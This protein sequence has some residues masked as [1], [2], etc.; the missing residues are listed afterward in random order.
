MAGIEL[1]LAAKI[2]HV[3]IDSPLVPLERVTLSRVEQLQAAEDPPGLR[4]K[5]RQDL[6]LRGGKREHVRATSNLVAIEIDRQVA[7][8]QQPPG[9][10]CWD[11]GVSF[12][13]ATEH[14]V[15]ARDE[16]FR[17][18]RLDDVIVGPQLQ[19]DD[20]V[21]DLVARRQHDDGHIRRRRISAQFAAY[22]P[23]R[24][25]REHQVEDDQVGHFTS[26]ESQSHPTVVRGQDALAVALQVSLHDPNNLR[27]VVDDENA[28]TGQSETSP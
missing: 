21:G 24:N 23:A 27:L 25:V 9:S 22:L 16:L 13:A 7:V 5:C 14:G 20:P 4:G 15:D 18:K 2:L 3:A 12:S 10:H 1:E 28:P 26:R 19:P 6:K 11:A 17:I 8:L